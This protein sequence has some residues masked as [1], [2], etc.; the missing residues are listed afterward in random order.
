M[1]SNN[2]TQKNY[3][4]RI[5]VVL[6]IFCITFVLL[7]CC[8]WYLVSKNLEEYKI[9]KTNQLIKLKNSKTNLID[10]DNLE[11]SKNYVVIKKDDL[12][13]INSNINHL[14]EQVYSEQNKATTIIDK[15]IDRINLYM[16][17]GIGFIAIIGI[18]IPLVINFLSYDDLKEKLKEV[19][20]KTKDLDNK[21]LEM[22]IKN[23]NEAL[24]K[25]AEIEEIKTKVEDVSP[26][27]STISLQIALNRINNMTSVAIKNIRINK[28][29]TLFSDLFNHLKDELNKYKNDKNHSVNQNNSLIEALKDFIQIFN[30][31]KIR[32]ASILNKKGLDLEFINLTSGL[33]K[34]IKSKK[35]DEDKVYEEIT[36]TIDNILKIFE[37]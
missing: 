10:I 26:K 17:L 23:A 15:D 4:K 24:S 1:S 33:Q 2:K 25:S 31:E 37:E 3:N 16:A 8:Q 9:E 22:A 27:V 6:V 36:S 35:E 28:D 13:E 30:D 7:F 20:D 32:F 5:V 19:H 18:F 14:A 12:E 34:L 29:Y 11:K 21:E